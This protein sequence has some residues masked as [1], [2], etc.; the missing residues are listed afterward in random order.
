MLLKHTGAMK[1]LYTF[2]ICAVLMVGGAIVLKV[3]DIGPQSP[4]LRALLMS[5][6]F[7]IPAHL[8]LYGGFAALCRTQLGNRVGLIL[9]NVFAVALAQEAAQSVL[10]GRAPG[11]GELFDLFVDAVAV[12]IVLLSARWWAHEGDGSVSLP[13]DM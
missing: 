2:C 1:T 5:E 7:H 6:A 13:R 8:V 10:F 11:P 4:A 9:F 3:T 12:L